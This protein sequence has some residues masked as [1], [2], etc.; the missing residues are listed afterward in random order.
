MEISE[1]IGE[2]HT[3]MVHFV[4]SINRQRK[5]QLKSLLLWV[6]SLNS[7]KVFDQPAGQFHG[8]ITQSRILQVH[9]LTL[10][11]HMPISFSPLRHDSLQTLPT[12]PMSLMSSR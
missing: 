9:G 10:E 2:T 3:L 4:S 6:L 1:T 11:R 7:V 12:S 8:V 5:K